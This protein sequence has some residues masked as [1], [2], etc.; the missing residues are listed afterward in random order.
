MKENSCYEV[1]SSNETVGHEENSME[2]DMAEMKERLAVLEEKNA[3][4]EKSI[5]QL[6]E[7]AEAV[8]E[9]ETSR[10]NAHHR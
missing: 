4:M 5:R 9:F 2:K 8:Y 1:N 6:H 7:W 3:C 10:L